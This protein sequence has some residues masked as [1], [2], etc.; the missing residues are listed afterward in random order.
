[1]HFSHSPSLSR[2]TDKEFIKIIFKA[3]DVK[4]VRTNS[5]VSITHYSPWHFLKEVI[6]PSFFF[7]STLCN[8]NQS[9]WAIS[10]TILPKF[11]FSYGSANTKYLSTL[12]PIS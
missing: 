6:M 9:P 4:Q 7:P 12:S 8:Q 5:S 2:S 11:L 10:K 1:M 3:Q